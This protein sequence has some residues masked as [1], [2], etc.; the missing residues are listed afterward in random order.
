M[1]LLDA[2]I[3]QRASPVIV[4]KLAARY[5]L[6]EGFCYMVS[7]ALKMEFVVVK[8]FRK[9]GLFGGVKPG[10]A[11]MM[12]FDDGA[13]WKQVR[14]WRRSRRSPMSSKSMAKVDR[15]MDEKYGRKR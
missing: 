13:A 7:D 9:R 1:T 3:I 5:P 8:S 14:P 4:P 11:V 15:W 10:Y 6:S 12:G 2:A